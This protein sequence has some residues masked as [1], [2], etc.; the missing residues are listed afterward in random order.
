MFDWV[1][2]ARGRSIADTYDDRIAVAK[3]ADQG[4]LASYHIAEHHGATLGL[5]A[6]PG[7]LAAAVARETSPIRL[8]PMTFIVPLYDPLRL[9]EETAMIDQL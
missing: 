3:R 2:V 7:L 4:A 9:A 6:S 5:A 1:D 8:A